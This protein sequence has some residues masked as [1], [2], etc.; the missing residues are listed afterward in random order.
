MW[1]LGASAGTG[2]SVYAGGV[3]A[4]P[5][6]HLGQGLAVRASS[7]AGRH[8]YE[9]STQR[10]DGK[11]LGAEVALV[12]QMSGGRGWSNFSIGPRFTK[13]RL[14]PGDPENNRQGSRV[15]FAVQADGARDGE[16]WR[17]TWFASSGVIDV[18]IRRGPP[19][20]AG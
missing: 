3:L 18:S 11:Y 1:F 2:E 10:I 20:R 9:A 12:Y 16:K 17:L 19:C 15:D 8:R 14:S 13:T 7:N 5:G 6:G 4:V